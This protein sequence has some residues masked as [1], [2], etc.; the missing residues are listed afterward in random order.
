MALV[1][2]VGGVGAGCGEKAT[3]PPA[4]KEAPAPTP[5]WDGKGIPPRLGEAEAGAY[6]VQEMV[7]AMGFHVE[8]PPATLQIEARQ[9]REVQAVVTE[10]L[11]LHKRPGKLLVRETWP[12]GLKTEL[13]CDGDLA[14]SRGQ[15]KKLSTPTGA[16]L[17]DCLRGV[18]L[19]PLSLRET[20]PSAKLVE[21]GALDGKAVY[22]IDLADAAGRHAFVYVD[23]A[24]L[25]P[26]KIRMLGP[27]GDAE[28]RLVASF[29]DFRP[30]EGLTLPF[31]ILYEVGEASYAQRVMAYKIGPTLADARFTKPKR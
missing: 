2:L 30:V 19:D 8:A 23:A 31:Q 14:W 12:G 21:T 15:D 4:A 24:R 13:G 20:F 27:Q 9:H 26:L 7:E 18:M 16:A 22:K 28:S 3:P 5:T 6:V 1:C 29:Q 17:L 11:T 10:V 25:L